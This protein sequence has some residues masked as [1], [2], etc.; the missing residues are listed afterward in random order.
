MSFSL[1]K[2]CC[3]FEDNIQFC[4]LIAH[5]TAISD[6]IN[7]DPKMNKK[8]KKGS[9]GLVAILVMVFNA[10]SVLQLA[11]SISYLSLV[12]NWVVDRVSFGL[13]TKG[14]GLIWVSV[15]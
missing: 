13:R 10:T 14:Y 15:S 4:H 3:G 12:F 11:F 6:R 1:S 5:T 2:L 7:S 8:K 9:F